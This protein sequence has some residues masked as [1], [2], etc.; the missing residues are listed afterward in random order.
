MLIL[1]IA[2]SIIVWILILKIGD[3]SKEI[4]ELR[5]RLIDVEVKIII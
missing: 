1:F 2:L 4:K 3:L 5:S